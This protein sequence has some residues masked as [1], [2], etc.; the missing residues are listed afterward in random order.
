MW[1][2]FAN[3]VAHRST[4]RRR[5]KVFHC[6]SPPSVKAER[7]TSSLSWPSEHYIIPFFETFRRNLAAVVASLKRAKVDEAPFRYSPSRRCSNPDLTARKVFPMQMPRSSIRKREFFP[8]RANR[9]R[10]RSL[11]DLRFQREQN[12]IRKNQRKKLYNL[13]DISNE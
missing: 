9:R 13:E 3:W 4:R 8:H 1:D 7:G 10:F 11:S 2:N 6:F 5:E 12:Q